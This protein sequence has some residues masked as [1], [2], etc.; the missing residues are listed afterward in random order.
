MQ[1]HWSAEKKHMARAC[2]SENER[3]SS[4]EESAGEVDKGLN[5]LLGKVGT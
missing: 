2:G 3:Q 4:R 1:R 5:R